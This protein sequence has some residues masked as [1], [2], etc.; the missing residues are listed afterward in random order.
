MFCFLGSLLKFV[1]LPAH[2]ND[3]LCHLLQIWRVLTLYIKIFSGFG[4]AGGPS[5]KK[6]KI[7]KSQTGY[8][9]YN[10]VEYVTDSSFDELPFQF[11]NKLHSYLHFISPFTDRTFTHRT[12]ISFNNKYTKTPTQ[13]ITIT[14][15]KSDWIDIDLTIRR[16]LAFSLLPYLRWCF[17]SAQISLL[18]YAIPKAD[19][20]QFWKDSEWGRKNK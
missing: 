18:R 8:G 19:D 3:L 11:S 20:A 1:I 17:L 7:P 14:S 6:A 9:S 16:T 4:A 5:L 12:D 2:Y 13:T 10:C 15:I